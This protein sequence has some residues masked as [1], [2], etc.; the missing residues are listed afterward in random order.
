MRAMTRALA[1]GILLPALLAGCQALQPEPRLDSPHFPVPEGT[2]LVLNR[3]L[4]I[5]PNEV[6]T[7]IQ[8]GLVMPYSDVERYEPYCKFELRQLQSV[9]REVQPDTFQ[10]SEVERDWYLVQHRMPFRLAGLRVG[11]D[12]DAGGPA[13]RVSSTMM[14]LR[15]T[16]Q[17]DALRMTCEYWDDVTEARHLTIEEIRSALGDV[18]DLRL[19]PDVQQALP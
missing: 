4:T 7:Y 15:S 11:G 1:T 5:Q 3:P 14:W 9:A 2:E 13:F 16:A 10:V 17:P 18:F 12:E 6:S 19:P 8:F